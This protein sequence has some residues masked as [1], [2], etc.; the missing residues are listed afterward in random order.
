M[1]I[2]SEPISNSKSLENFKMIIDNMKLIYSKQ[3]VIFL[4]WKKNNFDKSLKS[5]KLHMENQEVDSFNR[6][7]KF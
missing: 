6:I 1:I 4:F 3:A 5:L 7:K 2:F